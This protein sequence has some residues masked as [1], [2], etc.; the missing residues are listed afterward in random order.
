MSKGVMWH[1]PVLGLSLSRAILFSVLVHVCVLI[2]LFI[3]DFVVPF[4]RKP[5]KISLST[6]GIGANML[7]P[8]KP[9]AK[10]LGEQR[11]LDPKNITPPA[12][13]KKPVARA[14]PLTKPKASGEA[15]GRQAEGENG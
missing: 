6:K 12:P 15:G 4:H 3:C 9:G 14:T 1:S 11:A 7:S 10:P 5:T 8:P 13:P 2:V